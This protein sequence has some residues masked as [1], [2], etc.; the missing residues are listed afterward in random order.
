VSVRVAAQA[1][2]GRGRMRAVDLRAALNLVATLAKYLGSAALVP[3]VVA[4]VYDDP[5][6]PFVVTGIAVCGG[7]WALERMTAEHGGIGVREGFLVVALTWL[8]A[9]TFGALPYVLSGDPQVDRPLDAYFE[10]MSGFTTTGA[11]IL[12]DVEALPTSLLFW[13]QFTQWLGGMGI[14]VLAL[15]VLPRLRVGGRQLLEQELPGPELEPLTARIRDT[16]RRLWFLYLGMTFVLMVVLALYGLTG[17]DDRMSVFNAVAY[18]FA[19]LPTGGFAPDASSLEGFAAA[20]QWTIAIAMIVAGVNY[21]LLYLAFVRRE[22]RKLPRDE[23]LRLYVAV[24]ALASVLLVTQLWTEGIATGEAAVRH[25][26]FQAASVMTTTGFATVDYAVWPTLALMTLV[27]LM[28]AGGSAGSTSGSVKIVRHLLLGKVLR[29]EL[30]QTVHP[31]LV[32]PVRLNNVIVDERALRAASSFILL[33]IGIF[34]VGTA[35]LAIDAARANLELSTIDAVAASASMLGNVGPG[36]GFAGPMG[37]FAPF[38]DFSN[39][40][41]IGL[42]WL[43]RLEVVP[44]IVLFMRSYWRS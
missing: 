38:S 29:R 10:A 17:I 39:A 6:W 8:V 16:A 1:P 12:T 28:F 23:E 2:A 40:V 30:D 26:V 19:T 20:S 31:E 18:A 24:L 36:L 22:P 13:R 43:G 35:L 4:F 44:V 27:A 14:I 34:I 15:A 5:V 3:A 41:M 21:A 9:A 33:Y 7:G 25:G 42:M 37:S 11:T 32:V